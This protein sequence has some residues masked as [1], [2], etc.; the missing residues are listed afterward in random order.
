MNL[1]ISFVYQ[2]VDIENQKVF[3]LKQILNYLKEKI[4]EELLL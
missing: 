2:V 1:Q 3:M 4:L